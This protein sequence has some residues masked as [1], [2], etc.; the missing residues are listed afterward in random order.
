MD[1]TLESI[2][3]NF[4]LEVFALDGLGFIA[5][6]LDEDGVVRGSGFRADQQTAINVAINESVE[7]YAFDVAAAQKLYMTDAS[8][9]SCGFASGI[10]DEAARVRSLMEGFERWCF[11]QW[12]DGQCAIPEITSFATTS[13]TQKLY[14][15]FDSVRWFQKDFTAAEADLS[16]PVSLGITLAFKGEG[17][18]AGSRVARLGEDVWEHGAVEAW[19]NHLNVTR[20]PLYAKKSGLDIIQRRVNYF[21]R[22]AAVAMKQVSQATKTD[23]PQAK[24]DLHTKI[25]EIALPF[26]VYRTVYGGHIPWGVGT[27]ERFVY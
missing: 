17:V 23:W 1:A 6:L 10:N 15:E 5:N 16:F 4:R 20:N 27:D 7:R 3:G 2:F 11:S 22:N 24:I 26:H 8:P 19:V 25:E 14:E 21:A 13:L 12:I 18:F 9:T